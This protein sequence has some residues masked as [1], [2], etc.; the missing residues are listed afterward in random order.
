V[1]ESRVFAIVLLARK[2]YSDT[3]G[4]SASTLRLEKCEDVGSNPVKVI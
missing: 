3:S 2:N 1:F 4:E